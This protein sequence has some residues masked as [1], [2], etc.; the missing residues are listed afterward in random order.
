VKEFEMPGGPLT[1]AA[2]ILGWKLIGS[3]AGLGAIGAGLAAVVVMCM[4]RPRDDKEWV[5]AIVSTVMSSV[6]GGSAFIQWQGIE[7]WVYTPFGLVA[8][9]GV[10]FACGL[11]GWALIRWFF[12]YVLKREGRGIDEI[13]REAKELVTK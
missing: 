2:G 6:C 10:A 7:H 11:P 13:V 1:G 5:V 3:L 4:T 12:N 8:L 9:L